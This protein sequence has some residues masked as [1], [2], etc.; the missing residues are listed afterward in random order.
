MR[1]SFV[2]KSSNA[3]FEGKKAKVLNDIYNI[4]E[5]TIKAGTTVI[6]EG[7]NSRNRHYLN[8]KQGKIEIYGVA[9]ENLEL[10]KESENNW[11]IEADTL[12]LREYEFNIIK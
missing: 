8:V 2:K 12:D 1:E 5:E 10:L 11:P 7:K 6:I 4:G 9:P 3:F